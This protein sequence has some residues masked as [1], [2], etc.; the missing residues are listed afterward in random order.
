[1]CRDAEDDLHGIYRK[2]QSQASA[3]HQE[4]RA[5][6]GLFPDKAGVK[7]EAGIAPA[8]AKQG[9]RKWLSYLDDGIVMRQ[10]LPSNP[11]GSQSIFSMQLA[12]YH[13]Q[14]TA[15]GEPRSQFAHLLTHKHVIHISEALARSGYP[16]YMLIDPLYTC[17]RGIHYQFLFI[18][19]TGQE[20][21]LLHLV[22]KKREGETPE[23][24]R[25]LLKHILGADLFTPFLHKNL[26]E[27]ADEV[28][29]G[30]RPPPPSY[31]LLPGAALD[32]DSALEGCGELKAMT[33]PQVLFE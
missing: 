30:P 3:F 13:D 16:L 33:E 7:T 5:R 18:R 22:L 23:R 10:P 6:R 17:L 2:Y 11:N 15:N 4:L 29:P 14:V 21:P 1:M 12:G 26:P 8:D 27:A 28:W 20:N 32:A 24:V 19:C 9:E 25:L 31:S